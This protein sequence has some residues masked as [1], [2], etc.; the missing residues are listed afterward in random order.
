M[1]CTELDEIHIIRE[2]NRVL[3]S[4]P[5]ESRCTYFGLVCQTGEPYQTEGLYSYQTW[6]PCLGGAE[7][8][9][10]EV[11]ESTR[12]VAGGCTVLKMSKSNWQV[13]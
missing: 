12:E 2:M 9:E 5:R 11:R 8:K 7:D 10:G 13:K 6:S 4:T 1:P 3:L